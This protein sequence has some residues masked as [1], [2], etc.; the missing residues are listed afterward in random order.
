MTIFDT[1][2]LEMKVPLVDAVL[3]EVAETTVMEVTATKE[4][5]ILK[6]LA[7]CDRKKP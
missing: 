5:W 1:I 3:M 6:T 7:T 2:L 4:G